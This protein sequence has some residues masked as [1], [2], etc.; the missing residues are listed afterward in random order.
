MRPGA[1]SRP[2][3]RPPAT[4]TSGPQHSQTYSVA[5]ETLEDTIT[6]WERIN[7]LWE[8]GAWPLLS[9]TRTVSLA[10]FFIVAP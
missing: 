10:Y 7:Q 6:C 8:E 5:V 1:G 3:E 2:S 9:S 4:A